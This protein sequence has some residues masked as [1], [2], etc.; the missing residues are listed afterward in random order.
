MGARGSVGARSRGIGRVSVRGRVKARCSSRAASCI[1]TA[2]RRAPPRLRSIVQRRAPHRVAAAP[3]GTGGTVGG[4]LA[5][6]GGGTRAARSALTAQC[7][8]RPCPS[9]DASLPCCNALPC[10]APPWRC[11]SSGA[12]EAG[13]EA[14]A[15]ACAE[16]AFAETACAAAAFAEAACALSM[17]ARSVGQPCWSAGGRYT[18]SIACSSPG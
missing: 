9:K 12:D 2:P 7:G 11:S 14:C 16:D 6:I 1:S 18:P 17:R 13:A 8:D 15:E 10:N 3:C 4:T 5:G